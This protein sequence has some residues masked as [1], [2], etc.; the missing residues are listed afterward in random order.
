MKILVIRFSSI[1]DIVLTSPVV[2]CL[3]MQLPDASIHF[4]TKKNYWATVEAN[5]YIDK[6][7]LLTDDNRSELIKALKKENFDEII[8][9]HHNL[10]TLGF[11]RAIGVPGH[12][13][14]KLN[15][16][17]WLL[18]ALKINRLPALHIVD[19]YLDTTAHLG[20]V[21]DGKGLD[22]FIPEGKGVKEQD[23]PH[24]HLAGYL[25][26]VIGAAH[27]TKQLPPEKLL[28]LCRTLHYPIILLGGKEDAETGQW[29][30]QQAGTHVYNAAGKFSLHESSDLV[31]RSNLVITHDTG[32][33]HI[34]AAFFKPII[35]IWG[36]TV[37]QFGMSQYYGNRTV[38][39][40]NFEVEKL[41]CRPCSKIGHHKCPKRHF[42]CMQLQPVEKIAAAAMQFLGK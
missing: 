4:L 11:K 12:A 42:N 14:N 41:S 38:W 39:N 33:M 28:E 6:A 2:R 25:A 34:A 29:L 30:Q 22:Y 19:R 1:G 40:V 26:L 20:I 7:W 5:P 31:R 37:P 24:G 27:A 23:I 10:R 36:N 17:K 8:D 35:C 9:L 18:T 3:R 13:F 16:E 21:N 15:Y 32:L